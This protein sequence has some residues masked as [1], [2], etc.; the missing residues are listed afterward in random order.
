MHRKPGTFLASTLLAASLVFF[1]ACSSGETPK[2]VFVVLDGIPADVLERAST[3]TIDAIAAAGGYTRAYIGG[4]IGGESESP[5]VSAVGYQSLLTGTWANKHNVRTNE[6]ENPNYRYWDIFRIAKHH[7]AALKT[8]VFSTWEDNR[9]RLIGDGLEQA[10][11]SKLDHFADGFEKDTE[12]FPHDELHTYIRDIDEHVASAAARYI[13]QSGPDLSWV[14]LQYTDDAG[15]GVGDSPL[16]L[17][18]VTEADAMV[19]GIWD[20]LQR[21]SASHSED[22][23]IVVTTDHGRDAA[24]GKDHG[25]QSERE[26]TIWIATNSERLNSHFDELPAIVDILPSIAAHL[27]LSMP[28]DIE[29]QLDGRSFIDRRWWR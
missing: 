19:A 2:A 13:A 24:T 15:H 14:Y 4:E 3:P 11:G 18:A 8:A 20:A 1:A 6:V 28:P 7:D 26:R 22:W 9:T 29:A 12:R 17:A 10:G 27:A 21:R 23:L 25:G 5:T 16:Q